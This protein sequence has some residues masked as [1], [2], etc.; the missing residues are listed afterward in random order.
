MLER[1][2]RNAAG[3]IS[4]IPPMSATAMTTSRQKAI[5]RLGTFWRWR[6]LIPGAVPAQTAAARK[7]IR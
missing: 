7:L 4:P 5:V 6:K 3:R 1:S 2:I